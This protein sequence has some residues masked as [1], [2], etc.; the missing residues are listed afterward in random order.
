MLLEVRLRSQ[1]SRET[2]DT[3]RKKIRKLGVSREDV[4]REVR[5]VRKERAKRGRIDS[6]A[7]LIKESE[8]SERGTLPKLKLLARDKLDRFD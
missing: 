3:V 1:S 4:L 6:S 5:I 8:K 7:K 2:L